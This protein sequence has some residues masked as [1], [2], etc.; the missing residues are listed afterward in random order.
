[1]RR[2]EMRGFIYSLGGGVERKGRWEGRRKRRA[3]WLGVVS[4]KYEK[5]CGNCCR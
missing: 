5:K 1:M 3:D 2:L 4:G